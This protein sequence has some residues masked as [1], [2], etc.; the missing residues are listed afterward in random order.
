M[1]AIGLIEV[2]GY[3]TA[4]EVS[5]V[6]V[7]SANVKLVSI[8]KVGSGIVT[9][10]ITGDVG[11]VKSAVELGEIAA[12]KIGLLRSV[13]VIPR[14]HKEVS[15]ILFKKDDKK[16]YKVLKDKDEDLQDIE[17]LN[18]SNINNKADLSKMSV[19]DL[20]IRAKKLDSSMTNRKLNALKKEELINLVDESSRKDK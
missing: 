13:H 11:A 15:D 3:V 7:K 4:I 14:V 10:T 6:C 17:V 2:I 9:L 18:E 8:D 19:K 1:N 5:D 20:K 12:K 16:E